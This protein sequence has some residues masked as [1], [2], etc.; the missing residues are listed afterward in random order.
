V[1]CQLAPGQGAFAIDVVVSGQLDAVAR[2]SAV[3]NV[4]PNPAND[5]LV[6][7]S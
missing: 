1:T 4:D 5:E 7:Q 6:F 2:V 3:D